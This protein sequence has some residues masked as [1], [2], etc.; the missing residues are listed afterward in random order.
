MRE[1]FCVRAAPPAPPTSGADARLRRPAA[2]NVLPCETNTLDLVQNAHREPKIV[3]RLRR[4]P[5]QTILMT[6]ET[7]IFDLVQN[8]ARE[9]KTAL[10]TERVTPRL[11]AVHATSLRAV[12]G[13][14]R[15]AAEPR[16][17]AKARAH[18]EG[19]PPWALK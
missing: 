19:W 7:N 3:G 1:I 2:T 15:S 18:E 6:L 4:P 10:P 13:K 9:P 5:R 12:A 17:F 14:P 8:A 16:G 11:G